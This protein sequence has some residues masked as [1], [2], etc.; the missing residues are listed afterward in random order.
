M[1][2]EGA[3]LGSLATEGTETIY[4]QVNGSIFR[5]LDVSQ[6]ILPFK[7]FKSLRRVLKYSSALHSVWPR[8][9]LADFSALLKMCHVGS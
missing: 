7:L 1:A 6:G 9:S 8:L 2:T 4:L 5:Q 3:T